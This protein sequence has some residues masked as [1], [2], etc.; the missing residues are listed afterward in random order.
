[1]PERIQKS[2]RFIDGA[3]PHTDGKYAFV[4]VGTK[5]FVT[6]AMLEMMVFQD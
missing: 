5:V 3:G 6:Q 2:S 1:M 4:Q